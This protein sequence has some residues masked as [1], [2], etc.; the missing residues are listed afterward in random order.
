VY[1]VQED[2]GCLTGAITVTKVVRCLCAFFVR[3]QGHR[4]AAPDA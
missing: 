2:F 1:F 4:T 3:L